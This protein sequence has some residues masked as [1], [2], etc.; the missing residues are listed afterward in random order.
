M[1]SKPAREKLK[2]KTQIDR[3]NTRQ[4]WTQSAANTYVGGQKKLLLEKYIDFL[5]NNSPSMMLKPSRS[6]S[7]RTRTKPRKIYLLFQ[8]NMLRN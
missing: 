7:A 2:Q 5:N 1:V 6:S 4:R 3:E 8:G